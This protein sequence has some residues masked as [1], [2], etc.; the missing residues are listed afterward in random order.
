MIYGFDDFELDAG[1]FELRRNGTL[2][3]VEPLVFDIL[4]FLVRNP[5]RVI[6][7]DEMIDAVWDGRIVSDA[8]ISS[9]IK[10]ARKAIGDSG[11]LQRY[12]QTVRGRGFRFTADVTQTPG[13]DQKAVELPVPTA[14]GPEPGGDVTGREVTGGSAKQ[15][16]PLR[17][18]T[19]RPVIAVIP[20]DNLSAEADAF[21]ADGL[22]EDIITNLARFRDLL[23]I[24]KTSSFQFR[25]RD[26]A[27]SEFCARLGA[28]FAVLGATRRAG[29]QVRITAQLVEATTGIHLWADSYDR[30]MEDIFAVQDEVTRT[31]AATLGV[32]VQDVAQQRALRKGSAELDAYDCVLRARRYTSMLNAETHLEARELLE[33]AIQLD[34]TNA[35]AH[36]LLANVY[37]AEHRFD[38]N[39]QSDP[40]GR[41]LKMA[42]TATALDGQNAYARCWLAIVHFFRGEN[43]KFEAEA[44][45]ALD[46][47]PNDP[48]ILADIG[49]F[50]AFLGQFERGVALSRQAQQLNPLHPGWYHFSFA[51]YHYDRGEYE[52]VLTEMERAGMPDFYWVFLLIAA[53]QGQ[54]GRPEAAGSLKKIYAL[55]PTFSA[56]SEIRKWNAAPDDL[57]HLMDGLRKAG[58]KE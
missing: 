20:F 51:R 45:R 53:A 24:S 15:T 35:D 9:G 43:D 55:K 37:L 4:L 32:K 44:Q 10:S 5:G 57:E 58:L 11:G 48:E 34:P 41:A 54:L 6:G 28:E 12:L 42:Q 2:C 27:L 36:A 47:N 7:R 40:I 19:K 46:L 50:L 31:I 16:A 29:G 21:F 25:G 23:V 33:R 8:T 18:G 56:A 30:Q 22:T 39:P 1:G 3:H 49:H 38:T 14:R 17:D 26:E 52:E 13:G